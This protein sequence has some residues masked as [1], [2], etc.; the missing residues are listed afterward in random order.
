MRELVAKDTAVYVKATL[1]SPRLFADGCPL[2]TLHEIIDGVVVREVRVY[3]DG[4]RLKDHLSRHPDWRGLAHVADDPLNNWEGN[5]AVSEYVSKDLF[6][7]EWSKADL[8][9]L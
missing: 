3:A 4:R 1:T 7:H 6:E 2:S 5:P 8:I 9:P